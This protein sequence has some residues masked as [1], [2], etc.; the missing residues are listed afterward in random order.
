MTTLL[1]QVANPQLSIRRLQVLV[2]HDD[3]A[4]R[5]AVAANPSTPCESLLRLLG[6]FPREVLG[7]AAMALYQLAD[8][9][10]FAHA[11]SDLQADWARHPDMPGW[12]LEQ[13][14]ASDDLA[15]RAGLACH[16]NTPAAVVERLAFPADFGDEDSE[17]CAEAMHHPALPPGLLFDVALAFAHDGIDREFEDPPPVTM[18]DALLQP[19]ATDPYVD[20]QDPDL[21]AV[22]AVSLSLD[23]EGNVS[24][25]EGW[26]SLTYRD[27]GSGGYALADSG[28][29][30][31]SGDDT[32]DADDDDRSAPRAPIGGD[33]LV[34]IWGSSPE[35]IACH[36]GAPWHLVRRSLFRYDTVLDD[37]LGRRDVPAEQL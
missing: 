14:G 1:D 4:V 30:W 26:G 10:L 25:E 8:P 34:S 15:V 35:Q 6:E 22:W 17:A 31:C 33:D 23:D 21:D 2:E 24:D 13:L 27:P 37:A 3:R 9:A 16:P 36:P 28:D 20:D 19:P 29:G 7:N 32:A 18:T 5:A 12:L 11:D